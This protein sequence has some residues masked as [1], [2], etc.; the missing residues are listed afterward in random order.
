[1]E[2]RHRV[3]GGEVIFDINQ[4][5]QHQKKK[6]LFLL[7]MPSQQLPLTSKRQVIKTSV[8]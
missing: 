1:M 8:N 4:K 7:S 2:I 3:T 5:L 6:T